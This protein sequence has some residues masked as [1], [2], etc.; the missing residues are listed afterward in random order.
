[1]YAAD[2]IHPN[3]TLEEKLQLIY[4]FRAGDKRLNLTIR[5][6]YLDLLADLGNPHLH[7]PPVCAAENTKRQHRNPLYPASCPA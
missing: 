1:M 3:K 6:P 5:Q 4:T 2:A 7:L